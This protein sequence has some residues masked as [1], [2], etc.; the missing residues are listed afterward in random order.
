M[1]GAVSDPGRLAGPPG[2]HARSLSDRALRAADGRS[3]TPTP[4]SLFCHTD[5]RDVRLVAVADSW[6]APVRPPEISSKNVILPMA[7][8]G[9]RKRARKSRRMIRRMDTGA[10][11]WVSWPTGQDEVGS[12]PVRGRKAKQEKGAWIFR[13]GHPPG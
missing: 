3:E 12:M 1:S 9:S 2:D 6:R 8:S 5:P 11:P 7:E 13:E 10:S 4:E